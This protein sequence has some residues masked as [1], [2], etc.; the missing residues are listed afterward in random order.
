MRA[1]T[2]QGGDRGDDIRVGVVRR[3]MTDPTIAT[4]D[5][6]ASRQKNKQDLL[7]LW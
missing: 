4:P 1:I 6:V 7:T 5:N 3:T 2:A